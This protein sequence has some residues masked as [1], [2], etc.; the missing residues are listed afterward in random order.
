MALHLLIVQPGGDVTLNGE[1]LIVRYPAGDVDVVSTKLKD[2]E[3]KLHSALYDLYQ[4]SDDLADG[5]EFM[6]RGRVRFVCEGV[7]VSQCDRSLV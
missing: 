3:Q 6:L 7:H 5:D 4:C 2:W 1:M